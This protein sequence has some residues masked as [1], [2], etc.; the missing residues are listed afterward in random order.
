MVLTA[1]TSSQSKRGTYC[2]R[3]LLAKKMKRKSQFMMDLLSLNPQKGRQL[4]IIMWE[5]WGYSEIHSKLIIMEELCGITTHINKIICISCLI[6]FHQM[7]KNSNKHSQV[8]FKTIKF[9][10][11]VLANSLIIIIT[12]VHFTPIN[13]S[14]NQE[15]YLVAIVICSKDSSN[16]IQL[17]GNSNNLEIY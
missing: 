11:M 14:N 15:T 7:P 2:M 10:K 9:L 8:Y 4:S 1:L 12:M 5:R 13:S 3:K 6:L 16:C 17:K